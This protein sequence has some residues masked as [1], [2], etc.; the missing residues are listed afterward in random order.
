MTLSNSSHNQGRE[1]KNFLSQMFSGVDSLGAQPFRHTSLRVQKK[2]DTDLYL[3]FFEFISCRFQCCLSRQLFY[4]L[5]VWQ[6]ARKPR[7]QRA[8]SY[9]RFLKTRQIVSGNFLCSKKKTLIKHQKYTFAKRE[10]VLRVSNELQ[11]KLPC[12][13]NKLSHTSGLGG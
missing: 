8:I 6:L 7:Q 9:E 4:P 2:K 5:F 1:S 3:N 12:K 13:L 10:S 11:S